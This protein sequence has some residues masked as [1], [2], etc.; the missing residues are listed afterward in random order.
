MKYGPLFALS[1]LAIWF[2]WCPPSIQFVICLCLYDGF[3]TMIDLNHLALLADLA[4]SSEHRTALNW[5][6]SVFSGFGSLSVFLSYSVW[7]R[8]NMRSFHV[9]CAL[10]AL[11]ALAGFLVSSILLKQHFSLRKVK[12]DTPVDENK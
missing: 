8:E 2:R 7:D 5:Y 9:F 12:V 10:L 3:L 4:L 1:F 6:C 11:F